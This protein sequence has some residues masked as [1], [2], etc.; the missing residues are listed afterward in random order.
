MLTKIEQEFYQVNP[1]WITKIDKYLKDPTDENKQYL[2]TL[3]DTKYC[4]VGD[5]RYQ[6]GLSRYYMKNDNPEDR[7]DIC[8]G[9]GCC[10]YL[11]VFHHINRRDY[12]ISLEQFK[13]HLNKDHHLELKLNKI[14][15]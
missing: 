9:I 12:S 1:F 5:I 10:I 2:N 14:K 6:L 13:K 7:C 8:T 11:E 4:L 15:K 3:S